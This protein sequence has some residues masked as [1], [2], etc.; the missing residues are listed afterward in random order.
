[1][2]GCW[3]SRFLL[4]NQQENTAREEVCQHRKLLG[5]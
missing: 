3:T 4:A 1:M 5:F 2:L